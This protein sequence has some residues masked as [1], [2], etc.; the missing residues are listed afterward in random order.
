MSARS[1]GVQ[2]RW[3]RADVHADFPD[4]PPRYVHLR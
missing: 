3:L 2:Q 1:Q 4:G